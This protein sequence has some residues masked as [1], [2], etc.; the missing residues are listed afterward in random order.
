MAE[1]GSPEEQALFYALL[2]Q[3][4]LVFDLEQA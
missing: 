4:R 2:R 3:D 1:V